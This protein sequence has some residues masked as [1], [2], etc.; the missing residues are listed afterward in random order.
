MAG[1]VDGGKVGLGCSS[2]VSRASRVV[3]ELAAL[4]ARLAGI[5]LSTSQKRNL[6]H[7]AQDDTGWGGFVVSRVRGETWD[8]RRIVI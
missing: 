4:V 7:P 1:G 5:V 2:R 3:S 8:N 6:G